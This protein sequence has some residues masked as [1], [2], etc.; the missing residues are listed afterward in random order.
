MKE[1]NQVHSEIYKTVHQ[2]RTALIIS[3]V[4]FLIPVVIV[5]VLVIPCFQPAADLE[6][7]QFLN[8]LNVRLNS[9]KNELD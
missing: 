3:V 7:D 5:L 1:I 2:I 4:L 8:Q 6:F 9:K